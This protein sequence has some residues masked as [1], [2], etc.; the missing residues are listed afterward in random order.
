MHIIEKLNQEYELNK[1]SK[2]FINNL[3]QY[4]NVFGHD[5]EALMLLVKN[6]I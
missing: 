3:N 5:G 4:F 2:V 6:I 1:E